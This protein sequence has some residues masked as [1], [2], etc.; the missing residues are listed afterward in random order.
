MKKKILLIGL[1]MKCA[2]SEKSFLSFINTLD[3]TEY[4][5]DLI[6]A[7]KEGLFLDQIP[8][9]VNIIEM[10]AAGEVFKLS[11]K[12]AVS[13]IWNTYIKKNPLDK[14]FRMCYTGRRVGKPTRQT[15]WIGERR[16][17]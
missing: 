16:G 8:P 7:K 3:F 4:E 12:N 2:G 17:S 14:Y 9:E 5:A 15:G 1:T 11:S 10:E 6:L 13:L